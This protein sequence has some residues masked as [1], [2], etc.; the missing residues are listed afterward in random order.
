MRLGNAVVL[1]Q[2]DN[3]NDSANDDGRFQMNVPPMIERQSNACF[4]QT[5]AMRIHAF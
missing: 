5:D 4:R 1:W 3:D 2:M